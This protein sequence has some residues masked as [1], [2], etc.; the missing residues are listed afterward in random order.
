[1]AWRLFEAYGEYLGKWFYFHLL[2]TASKQIPEKVI[3]KLQQM[4]N[5]NLL[6]DS[7]DYLPVE[8]EIKNI[9]DN[10]FEVNPKETYLFGKQILPIIDAQEEIR[11]G[12][13]YGVLYNITPDKEPYDPAKGEELVDQKARDYL[14][15]LVK[16]NPEKARQE[17]AFFLGCKSLYLL[18]LGLE[19]FM[20]TPEFYQ[21]DIYNLFSQPDFFKEYD[22]WTYSTY[23]VR[24]LLRVTYP[25][26]SHQE[27]TQL[28][29]CILEAT[30]KRKKINDQWYDVPLYKTLCAI[31]ENIRNQHPDLKKRFQELKRKYPEYVYN[32]DKPEGVKVF[33][34]KENRLPEEAY[35]EMN[36]EQWITSFKTIQGNDYL[37]DGKPTERGH[38]NAFKEEIVKNPDKFMPLL[39]QMAN[40]EEIDEA[41][42]HTG[43]DTLREID[44]APEKIKK[45][46][47]LC[48]SKRKIDW[49][50]IG[51]IGYFIEKKNLD[52]EI[53]DFLIE[54]ILHTPD[55]PRSPKAKALPQEDDEYNPR[56]INEG[57]RALRGLSIDTLLDSCPDFPEFSQQIFNTLEQIATT[58]NP[59]T[60]ACVINKLAYLNHY[61]KQRTLNL[62]LLLIQDYNKELLEVCWIPLQYIYHV[63]FARLHDFFA[64][65][66]KQNLAPKNFGVMLMYAWFNDYPGAKDLFLSLLNISK[67]AQIE[68]IEHSFNDLAD[69]NVKDKAAFVFQRFLSS[70]NVGIIKTYQHKFHRLSSNDFTLLYPLLKAYVESNVGQYRLNGFYKYLGKSA[71]Q[72]PEGCIRLISYFE[73]HQTLE[74]QQTHS[75]P[76]IIL[77]V[78]IQSYNALKKYNSKS[79]VLEQA[80]DVFDLMLQKPEY[81]Q[82][83]TEAMNA[84]DE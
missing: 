55:A 11:I 79:P 8:H 59:P 66:I 81:R 21:K 49:S 10:L 47:K 70:E 7:R 54:L 52:Q 44:Y 74:D 61:D 65:V 4:L 71:R 39:E 40:E 69:K 83:A 58:A 34:N 3:K 22:H 60:R 38:N 73:N 77:E 27:Q 51:F 64:N 5:V 80:M 45:L 12:G 37:W 75:Y 67:K 6:K 56:L 19:V 2:E 84:A 29:K 26:F 35:K 43:L 28:N 63:D 31:P 36:E 46:Y 62:F 18:S 30:P 53:I 72:N 13:H 48:L 32:N 42:L 68:A 76:R 33:V 50:Y 9:I 20:I 82:Y 14:R 17:A 15:I 25:F 24:E 41:F 1:M 16:N 78:L 23:Q 57:F